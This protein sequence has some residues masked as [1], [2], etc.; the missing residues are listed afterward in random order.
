M[1]ASVPAALLLRGHFPH[2]AGGKM[3]EHQHR[4]HE[5]AMAGTNSGFHIRKSAGMMECA[6][7]Q[8]RRIRAMM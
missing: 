2:A 6:A 5:N 4:S 1:P 3:H 8:V 7:P